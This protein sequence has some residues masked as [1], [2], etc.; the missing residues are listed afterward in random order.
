MNWPVKEIVLE[1]FKAES[2]VFRLVVENE[3]SMMVG[4]HVDGTTVSGE[5]N[6]CDKFFAR[7]AER[8]H[9]RN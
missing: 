8:F 7:L 5:K 3:K 1:T 4:V 9:F 6:V 2:R